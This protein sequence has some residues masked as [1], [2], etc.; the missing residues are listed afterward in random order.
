MKVT[1]I[2]LLFGCICSAGIVYG[3]GLDFNYVG[4]RAI[5]MG[6]AFTGVADDSTAVYWNPAGL[7]QLEPDTTDTELSALYT[8]YIAYNYDAPDGKSYES[9]QPVFIPGLFVGRS[10]GDLAFGLGVY[11][12]YG[13]GGIKFSALPGYGDT[14]ASVGFYA[15]GLSA[16]YRIRSDVSIGLTG[17]VAYGMRMVKASAADLE[18]DFSGITGYRV[19]VGVMYQPK[20]TLNLGLQIKSPTKLEIEGTYRIGAYNLEDSSSTWESEIPWYILAGLEY[21]LSSEMSL[22]FDFAYRFYSQVEKQPLKSSVSNIAPEETYWDD[23]YNLNIGLEYQTPLA[24]TIRAGFEYLKGAVDPD[25]ISLLSMTDTDA[26][27]FSLGGGY[28]LTPSLELAL[29]LAYYYGF[30]TENELDEQFRTDMF[31]QVLGLKWRF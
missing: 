22:A 18:Q 24:L 4:L 6:N 20:E 19:N 25:K 29:S 10:M 13:A 28:A 1:K 8:G 15:L 16:A 3:A 27:S 12:E 26:L 30:E 2:V 17:E 5:G 11:A 31:M 23:N 7:T 9:D 14:E 21:K